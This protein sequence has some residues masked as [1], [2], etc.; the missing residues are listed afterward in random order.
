MKRGILETIYSKLKPDVTEEDIKN[1]YAM[2]KGEQFIKI[3][4]KGN[5]PEIKS[6]TGSNSFICGFDIN[7][8]TNTLILVSVI[9]NLIKGAAGQA[10]QNM[11]ILFNIAE[12]EG[13][14]I[15]S[16]YL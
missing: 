16:W 8:R 2:Y 12:N 5:T 10:V 9:D 1:A 14:N 7:T 15:G 13:L 11:N 4:S 3:L 6:V